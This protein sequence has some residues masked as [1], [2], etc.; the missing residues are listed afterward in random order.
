MIR[1][2]LMDKNSIY[3]FL[4]LCCQRCIISNPGPLNRFFREI[5]NLQKKVIQRHKDH[6]EYKSKIRIAIATARNAPAHERV[7]STLREQE[8]QV[9][10][11]LFLGGIEKRRVL[12]VFN[13]Q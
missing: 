6:K 3:S 5:S 8:I 1:V 4:C 11:A 12:V 2:K 9:D 13:K 10:V 7:I